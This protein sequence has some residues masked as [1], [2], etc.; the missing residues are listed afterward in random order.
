[1]DL[2][3]TIT[4]LLFKEL[5]MRKYSIGLGVVMALALS[6]CGG[7]DKKTSTSGLLSAYAGTWKNECQ[8]SDVMNTSNVSM[9][10]QETHTYTS[11]GNNLTVVYTVKI[12]QPT[13]TT[14]TG[15]VAAT[16]TQNGTITYKNTASLTLDGASVSG[17]ETTLFAAKLGGLSSGTTITIGN[18]VYPGDYFQTDIN[19]PTYYMHLKDN[20]IY[21]GDTTT[22]E[23]EP[24]L[25]KVE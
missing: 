9:N 6:A 7:D 1:M 22:L 11:N 10:D 19:L 20:Q 17:H 8:T 25:T 12:Y 2:V 23:T 5:S 4:L 18:L 21:A 15:P 13:D 14:C 24:Y 3:I 16:H